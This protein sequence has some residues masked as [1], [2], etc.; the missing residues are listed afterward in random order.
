MA[1][2][3]QTVCQ[4]VDFA[5]KI[6]QRGVPRFLWQCETSGMPP[7]VLETGPWLAEAP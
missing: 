6:A 3:V 2:S 4:V 1:Y 7:R 5:V